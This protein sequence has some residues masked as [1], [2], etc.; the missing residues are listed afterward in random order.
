MKLIY[1]QYF[2]HISKLFIKMMMFLSGVFFFLAQSAQGEESLKFIVNNE[3]YAKNLEH[4]NIDEFNEGE[5]FY[6]GHF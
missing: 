3:T 2:S 4:T 6:R 1:F 5:T